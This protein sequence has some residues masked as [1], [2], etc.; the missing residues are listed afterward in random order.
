MCDRLVVSRP[1][2]RRPF[3]VKL[4]PSGRLR[5]KLYRRVRSFV[6]RSG[7]PSRGS[8]TK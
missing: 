4:S 7:E 2:R 8:L 5:L 6:P 1:G 3:I